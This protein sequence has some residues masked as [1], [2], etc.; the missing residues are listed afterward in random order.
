ADASATIIQGLIDGL[1]DFSAAGASAA[2]TPTVLPT[3]ATA[4][5]AFTVAA[6]NAGSDFNNVQINFVDLSDASSNT[7]ATAAF[8]DGQNVLT[9]TYNSLAST[10]TNRDFDAI[11]SA[12]DAVVDSSSNP[13]FTTTNNL[14]ALNFT[15]P[16]ETLSTGNTGGEVLLDNLVF[17]LNGATGAETFNFAAG[18]SQS[19]VAAAINLVSDS[20]GVTAL[21]ST[22]SPL[23][24]TSVAYG[25][26]ALI[27]ID[28]ITEGSS[29]TFESS[30]SLTRA[31]GVDIL[32]TVNGVEAN[33]RANTLS[34]NTSSLDLSIT[35]DDGSDA[36]FNFSITGGGALFQLGPDVTSNQQARLG[37]ASVST[38]QLGGASGR[39]YELGSGQAKS[40][41]NDVNG[42]ARVIDEVVDKVTS[43]RGRLGAFQATSL[44]SNLVSLNETL[45]NLSEAES[46]I[47]DADFAQ[48][49]ANLTRAQ[50]LVQSGTNVLSLANQN[51]QNVLALLQ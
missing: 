14:G 29:G 34:I 17:Q 39:L 19:Q 31:I 22:G 18:T 25:T 50:I 48:E 43:L 21:S 4:Q 24:L 3:N 6:A 13:L 40:L 32:A 51:P 16:A 28:V 7:A 46:S 44:E 35:V 5:D 23:Q 30:L 26:E 41:T 8:D 47:R 33:A 15:P 1:A 27:N 36:N 20:I 38:G 10:A 37:I 11:K 12:I 9:V 42:A 2:G 45:A 49:S